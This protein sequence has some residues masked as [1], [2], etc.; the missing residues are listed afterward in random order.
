[1]K[2]IF[3]I[4]TFIGI[5][6]FS[7]LGCVTKQM[8]DK[9]RAG[10]SNIPYTDTIISFY[11]NKSSSKIEFIG[12]K[13]HYIL[14]D[15]RQEFSQ[16]MEAKDFLNLSQRNLEINTRTFE[17]RPQLYTHI[18]IK[19]DK[20]LVNKKQISWLKNHNFRP[21]LLPPKAPKEGEPIDVNYHPTEDKILAYTREFNLEGKR[22]YANSKVN[23]K[24]PKLNK[25]LTLQIDE[26][27]KDKEPTALEEAAK[28]PLKILATPFTLAADAVMLLGFTF[29]SFL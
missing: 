5:L 6:V 27:V 9:K 25:P 28:V 4:I 15:Y 12:E 21:L 18:R 19:F 1:M 29:V 26:S 13:Y 22:Y 17:K 3:V 24:L 8:W 2:K 23:N 20:S 11:I 14:R 16:L 10:H 7:S